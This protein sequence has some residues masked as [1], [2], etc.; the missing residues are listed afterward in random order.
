MR[1]WGTSLNLPQPKQRHHSKIHRGDQ[2]SR[3]APTLPLANLP[4][5]GQHTL[6]LSV[7]HSPR[8]S[9]AKAGTNALAQGTFFLDTDQRL[10]ACPVRI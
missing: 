8:R 5:P 9:Q 2:E 7:V 4:G 3:H 10:E 1:K 6:T